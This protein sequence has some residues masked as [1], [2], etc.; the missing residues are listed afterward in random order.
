[1]ALGE[2]GR[3][4]HQYGEGAQA[5]HIE[6]IKFGGTDLAENCVVLCWPCHY[7]A[8]EGGNYRHGTVVGRKRDYPYFRKLSGGST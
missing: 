5:H 1:V 4:N 2:A 3:A 8:H 7:S 6:H